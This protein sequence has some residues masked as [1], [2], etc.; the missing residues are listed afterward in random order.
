MYGKGSA[1]CDSGPT[2]IFAVAFA[3]G[4]FMQI[5]DAQ[6]FIVHNDHGKD[7]DGDNGDEHHDDDEG[8]ICDDEERKR[9]RV[10]A[11]APLLLCM[12]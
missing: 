10:W 7:E 3:S 12:T 9:W 4:P 11:D 8:D 5:A 1:I 2:F 6:M